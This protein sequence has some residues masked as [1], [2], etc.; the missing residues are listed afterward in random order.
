MKTNRRG[1]THPAR[2]GRLVVAGAAVGAVAAPALW[3][4]P[5]SA[6]HAKITIS[7]MTTS[8]GTVLASKG[9]TVYTL[10][11]SSTPCTSAC[12]AFWPPVMLASSQKTPNA[13]HGVQ[14]SQ[15]GS[16][17]VNGGRQ[18]TFEGHRLYWYAGDHKSGQVNGDITDEWGKWVAATM[19]PASSTSSPPTTSSPSTSSSPPTT[20]P[21]TTS[22][23]SGTG[24][25][26]F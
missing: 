3:A 11:P 19:A 17:H 6:S 4:T 10:Q 1:S 7:T 25:A 8:K 15:L 2:I 23:N 24:G 16:V 26:S 13:G 22:S 21:P 5:A 20:S 9:K 12:F 18:A 14:K